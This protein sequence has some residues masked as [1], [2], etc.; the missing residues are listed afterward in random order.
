MPQDI[1]RKCLKCKEKVKMMFIK[2]G[3]TKTGKRL[4]T[5]GCPECGTRASQFMKMEGMTK[6]KGKKKSGR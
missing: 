2:E 1:Q 5:F 3:L 6:G 4:G